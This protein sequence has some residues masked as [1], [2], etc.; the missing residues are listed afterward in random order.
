MSSLT[1]DKYTEHKNSK[2][3]KGYLA[4]WEIMDAYNMQVVIGFPVTFN[5]TFILCY[6]LPFLTLAM[7]C[8]IYISES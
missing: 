8:Y 4:Y 2:L 7:S 5:H 6:F 1:H 3:Y